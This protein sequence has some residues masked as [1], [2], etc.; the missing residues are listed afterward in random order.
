MPFEKSCQ[1][2][3]ADLFFP[4]DHEGDIARQLRAGLQIS[5]DGFEVREVL[6]FVIARATTE[7]RAALNP[8][9]KGRRFPQLKR[10]GRLHIVMAI[11][12]EMWTPGSAGIPAGADRPFATRRQGCRRPQRR[13]LCHH[14]WVP[15]SW[16]EPR[17]QPYLLAMAHH[18]FGARV[19]ILPML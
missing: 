5:F 18:P 15:L 9:L 10:L 12:D 3:A 8:R 6:P 16:A 7:Q 2:A 11:Y 1:A 4:L 13:G 17:L 19:Q 14:N